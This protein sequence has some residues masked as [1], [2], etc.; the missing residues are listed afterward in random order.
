MTYPFQQQTVEVNGLQCIERGREFW[1]C[2]VEIGRLLGYSDPQKQIN[3]LYQRHVQYLQDHSSIVN[4]T[5]EV[6]SRDVRVF[7]EEGTYYLCM[8][9]E[10]PQASEIS[11]QFAAA[12][13]ELRRKKQQE[14]E[15]RIKALE[16]EKQQALEAAINLPQSVRDRL[17]GLVRYRRMGLTNAEAARL[18]RIS[19]HA[20]KRVARHAIALGLIQAANQGVLPNADRER[21]LALGREGHSRTAI[22]RIVGRSKDTIRRVLGSPAALGG[23]HG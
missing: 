21:I 5:I 3:R 17:P 8:K 15:R 14:Q 11:L 9:A 1:F 12:L 18:L 19:E 13:K 4:M 2:G 10:T 7:D 23:R 16:T 22:A 20:A 6:G